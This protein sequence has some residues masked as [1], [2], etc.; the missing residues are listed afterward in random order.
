MRWFDERSAEVLW[1]AGRLDEIE[2]ASLAATA[3]RTAAQTDAALASARATAASR[4]GDAEIA[5]AGIVQALGE[6][7]TSTWTHPI[8]SDGLHAEP[9]GSRPGALV[10]IGTVTG[11]S[12]AALLD[13]P[14]Q[15]HIHL[16][17]RVGAEADAA[18]LL[19]SLLLRALLTT[20]DP[21]LHSVDTH[22][23]G[24]LVAAFSPGRSAVVP[25]TTVTE[26]ATANQ[27]DEL[28]MI[29]AEITTTKLRGAYADIDDYNRAALAKSLLPEAH[30]FVVVIN[31]GGLEKRA[32]SQLARLIRTGHAAGLHVIT[33]SLDGT[34]FRPDGGV[35]VTV[36]ADGAVIHRDGV[37]IPVR[38]D[39]RPVTSFIHRALDAVVGDYKERLSQRRIDLDL[40]HASGNRW[41]SRPAAAATT[42]IGM[43][44]EERVDLGFHIEGGDVHA[45]VVGQTGSG[46]SSLLHALILGLAERFSPDDVQ[47]FLVDGKGGVEMGM[48]AHDPR[49]GR[50]GLPHARVVAVESDVE[51]YVSVLQYLDA[52]MRRRALLLKQHGL[53][54]LVGLDPIMR[55]PRYVAVLDEFHVLLTDDRYRETAARY[56]TDIAKQGRSVGIHLVLATQSTAGLG[57]RGENKAL[58][59]NLGLRVAFRSDEATSEQ[60]LGG[61]HRAARLTGAGQAY[62]KRSLGDDSGEPQLVQVA[63]EPREDR[64]SRVAQLADEARGRGLIGVPVVERFV[65]GDAAGDP[66]TTCDPLLAALEARPLQRRTWVG[67]PTT[68]DVPSGPLLR[69]RMG[70]NAVLLGGDARL[71]GRTV[72]P[73]V[74]GATSGRRPVQIDVVASEEI[75]GIAEA[76]EVLRRYAAAT[77]IPLRIWGDE[78]SL[79]VAELDSAIAEG[80]LERDRLLVVLDVHQFDPTG[81]LENVLHAGPARGVHS[82]IWVRAFSD[83]VTRA[84]SKPVNGVAKVL[85]L[86]ATQIEVDVSVTDR[87]TLSLPRHT[88]PDGDRIVTWTADDANT[89]RTVVPYTLP[90]DS[91]LEV[92]AEARRP[93]EPFLT[94]AADA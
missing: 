70:G 29:V 62:V 66:V 39:D 20:S 52:E 34:P 53:A 38:L 7:L 40:L 13:H 69:R 22:G 55:L 68:I 56:L 90:T 74:I 44:G 6:R 21:V 36:G 80:E 72:V 18:G 12:A 84:L 60:M 82:I 76:T 10:R 43:A 73:M 33:V 4:T 23:N 78:V 27:L 91:E 89:T 30:R 93:G 77:D 19:D 79:L 11:T 37:G 92:L 67:A 94:G 5:L 35:Q 86:F 42:P 85:P 54:N 31:P 25:K 88:K 49:T 41:A 64:S 65:F 46:K 9:P 24:R 15:Q 59:D 8:W 81:V 17:V 26:N 3:R 47:F 16:A 71:A 57:A 28:S 45:L 51:M 61:D 58:F 87:Q 32:S 63:F 75:D 1:L 48:Y 50:S 14:A 2:R 83:L